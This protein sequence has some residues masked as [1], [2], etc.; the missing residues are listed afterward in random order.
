MSEA[1]EEATEA[2]ERALEALE[3]PGDDKHL[4]PERSSGYTLDIRAIED[5]QC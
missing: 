5:T 1:Y 2:L 3:G 4:D